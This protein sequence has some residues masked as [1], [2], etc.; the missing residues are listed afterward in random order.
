MFS[1]LKNYRFSLLLAVAFHIMLFSLVFINWQQTP[2]TTKKIV[3]KQGDVIQATAVSTQQYEDKIKQVNDKIKQK[4]DRKRKEEKKRKAELKKKKELKRKKELQRKKEIQKKKELKRKKALAKKKAVEK[5]KAEIKK[6]KALKLKKQKEKKAQ[7]KKK[8]ELQ[9]QKE[10][11]RKKVLQKKQKEEKKRKET[12]KRRQQA[13]KQRQAEIAAESARLKS[14]K[15]RREKGI[16]NRYAFQI[17][18]KITRYWR[19]PANVKLKMKCTLNIRMT[20][21]G[22]VVSVKVVRS[23]GDFAFDRAAEKAVTG[24]SPLPVPS[25]K[26]LFEKNF[27]NLTINYEK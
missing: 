12:E 7:E 22:E 8:K 26:T 13:E 17:Q 6:Q 24:A 14:D 2:K 9:K 18:N 11:Q 1:L 5:K 23:S 19:R 3:L 25:D 16:V 15:V 10:I 20:P 27:R 4:K 21:S